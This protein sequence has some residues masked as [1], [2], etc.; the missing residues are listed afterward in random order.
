MPAPSLGRSPPS[1]GRVGRSAR[2]SWAPEDGG[3]RVCQLVPAWRLLIAFALAAT[4]GGCATALMT[5][6]RTLPK[7]APAA[8]APTA[9]ASRSP[10]DFGSSAPHW[11]GSGG[12]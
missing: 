8:S 2:C 9:P 6:D 4:L 10:S 12:P 1:C 5:N 11:F 7:E 3:V